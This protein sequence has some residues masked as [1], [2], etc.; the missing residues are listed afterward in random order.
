MAGILAADLREFEQLTHLHQAQV[1]A[2]K[3]PLL[4]DFE[5]HSVSMFH[6]L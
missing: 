5:S 2:P 4:D 1:P 6:H 3:V